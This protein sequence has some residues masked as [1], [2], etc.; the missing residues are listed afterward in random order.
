MSTMRS[1]RTL[2]TRSSWNAN[3]GSFNSITAASVA[4][5]NVL[6]FHSS[7]VVAEEEKKVTTPWADPAMRQYK[8][9][10]RH[11][12]TNQGK[13]SFLIEMSPESIKQEAKILSLS[14]PDDDANVAVS[15][16]CQR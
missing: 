14:A 5:L 12:A 10:N 11:D 1:T 7:A 4:R 6:S 2:L 9:W 13:Y 3:K 8:F 16:S 15:Y